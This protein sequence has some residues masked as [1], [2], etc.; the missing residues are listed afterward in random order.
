MHK[1]LYCVVTKSYHRGQKGACGQTSVAA[2]A[3]SEDTDLARKNLKFKIKGENSSRKPEEVNECF[4]N[5]HLLPP[6]Y[7]GA[8]D[9]AGLLKTL[10]WATL[11]LR[12]GFGKPLLKCQVELRDERG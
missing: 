12:K 3:V 8:G 6:E 1:P 2:A 7:F 4:F 5:S 9:T 10:K 11:G